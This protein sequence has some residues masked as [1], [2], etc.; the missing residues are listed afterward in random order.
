MA[1]P[2]TNLVPITACRPHGGRA[3]CPRAAHAGL[4]LLALASLALSAAAGGAAPPDAV[5]APLITRDL[6]GMPGKEVTVETVEYPPGGKSP[7]HS[8][9]AQVFVY[10]LEGSLRMQVQGSP[11]VTLAPGATFYESPDDL[12]VVSEN[13]S[14]TKPA[15]FLVVMVKDKAP[16]ASR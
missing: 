12:H 4:A 10:V 6:V 8:H 14:A 15:K 7:P 13:A 11:L 9:H 2:R 5:V 16:G 1:M 3:P